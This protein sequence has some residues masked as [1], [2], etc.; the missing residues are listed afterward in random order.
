M[1][2]GRNERAMIRAM[3]VVG[4]IEKRNCQ[5]LVDMLGLEESLELDRPS[6]VNGLE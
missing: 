1:I 4:V 2:L 5:E 6:K 3:W